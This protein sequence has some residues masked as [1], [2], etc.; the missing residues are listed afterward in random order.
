VGRA[1]ILQLKIATQNVKAL[2]ILP[3]RLTPQSDV[4]KLKEETDMANVNNFENF[5]GTITVTKILKADFC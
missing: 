3:F 5:S 2:N 1:E 4:T